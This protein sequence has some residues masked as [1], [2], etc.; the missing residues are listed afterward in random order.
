MSLLKNLSSYEHKLN[1]AES[2]LAKANT[3]KALNE[4]IMTITQAEV[5]LRGYS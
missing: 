1:P 3:Y 5:L 4:I 2:I